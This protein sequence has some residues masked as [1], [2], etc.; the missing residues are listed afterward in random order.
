MCTLRDVP[1]GCACVVQR[2]HGDDDLKRRIMA[3]GLTRGTRVSV[4]NVAP[5]GDPL[6][7]RVRGYRLSI[8]KS[9][10]ARIDVQS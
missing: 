9:D 4:V 5:L 6:E 3:M 2:V 10:A 7:V 8:R 1:V